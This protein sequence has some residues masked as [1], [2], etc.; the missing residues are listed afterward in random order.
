MN[1]KKFIN[2]KWDLCKLW[3]SAKER[4]FI[5]ITIK[6]NQINLCPPKKINRHL[7]EVGNE[8]L[9]LPKSTPLGMFPLPGCQWQGFEQRILLLQIWPPGGH[10]PHVVCLKSALFK[11][12]LA[13]SSSSN[14][15]NNNNND[16][17]NNN[18]HNNNNHNSNNN[19]NNHNSNNNNNNHNSNNN[20][21]NSNNNNSSNNNNNHNNHNNNNNISNISNISNHNATRP[22]GLPILKACA[23][24]AYLFLP[25]N[26][27]WQ[28]RDRWPFERNPAVE[29]G[30]WSPIVFPL[31][32]TGFI[33]TSKTV[34]GNGI[35]EPSTVCI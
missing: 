32:M 3:A 15:N 25:C 24:A 33:Y 4:W 27:Q 2:P 34:V 35:S 10:W 13:P 6:K 8:K 9:F 16:N 20:N 29:V 22:L 26:S 5:D 30:S 21:N 19:N 17:N 28:R 31:F 1:W 18:N 11:P 23:E 12:P 7:E 14:N